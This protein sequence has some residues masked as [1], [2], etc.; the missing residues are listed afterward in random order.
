MATNIVEISSPSSI[1]AVAIVSQGDELPSTVSVAQND[2]WLE[3]SPILK[4]LGFSLDKNVV[5]GVSGIFENISLKAVKDSKVAPCFTCFVWVDE[6]I[7]FIS[8]STGKAVP[9][10]VC[11]L[12]ACASRVIS[13]S[14]SL[15]VHWL[16]I[17][18]PWLSGWSSENGIVFV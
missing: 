18:L 16:L 7:P 13:S 2:K 8:D 17:V 5:F 10:G 14:R 9:L 4:D 3:L 15:W 6:T 12:C 11:I 1:A